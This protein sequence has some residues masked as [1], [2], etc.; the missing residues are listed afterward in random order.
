MNRKISKKDRFNTIENFVFNYFTVIKTKK[1][2]L[3][4]KIYRKA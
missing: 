3:N 4:K 1:Y 2:I